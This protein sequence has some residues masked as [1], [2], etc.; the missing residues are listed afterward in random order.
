MAHNEH[1]I[2]DVFET[3]ELSTPISIPTINVESKVF[4]DECIVCYDELT[5]STKKAAVFPC[6]HQICYECAKEYFLN[7]LQNRV[8]I[9]CPICRAVMLNANSSEYDYFYMRYV[10][11]YKTDVDWQIGSLQNEVIL[12][13]P[14]VTIPITGSLV[15]I[16][17]TMRGINYRR[18]Q[19][20]DKIY[21]MIPL[22]LVIIVCLITYIM[23]SIR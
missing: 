13:I 16:P 11:M 17:L 10:D 15:T 12:N 23:Y 3:I 21:I 19:L 5:A 1:N 8:D 2:D 22:F 9:I 20:V 7:L 4:N 6:K 18:I 14:Q